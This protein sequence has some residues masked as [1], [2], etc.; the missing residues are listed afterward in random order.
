MTTS[1]TLGRADPGPTCEVTSNLSD[2]AATRKSNLVPNKHDRGKLGGE[3]SDSEHETRRVRIAH[4]TVRRGT[5][6]SRP[7]R[8]HNVCQER[9]EPRL[10]FRVL[11]DRLVHYSRLVTHDLRAISSDGAMAVLCPFWLCGRC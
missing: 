1:E 6:V 9:R 2:E 10:A 7:T 11:R 3:D 5:T 8:A 4:A